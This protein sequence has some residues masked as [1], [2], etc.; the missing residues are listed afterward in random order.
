MLKFLR[1]KSNQ[2]KIYIAIS[3]AVLPAFLIWGVML[4]ND[5]SNSDMNLGHV[6][7]RN[8]SVKDYLASYRAISR[9][10]RWAYGDRASELL[11]LLNLKGEAWDRILL[12]DYARRNGIRA[13]DQ[14]V[15]DWLARQ[16]IFVHD[17]KFDHALYNRYVREYLNTDSRQFEEEMRDSLTLDKIREGFKKEISLHD[18]EVRAAYDEANAS[19]DLTYAVLKPD[20]QIQEISPDGRTPDHASN[21]AVEKLKA[22]RPSLTPDTFDQQ[23]AAAGAQVTM[24]T[25]SQLND[26]LE[27]VGPAAY[28]KPTVRELNPNEISQP[29]ELPGG[30]AAIVKVT[31]QHLPADADY[32][33]DKESFRANLTE[34]KADEKMRALLDAERAKLK[35]NMDLMK[36]IFEEQSGTQPTG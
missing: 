27:H 1:H 7:S 35:L 23:L 22:L 11:P 36:Q 5:E 13:N 12:L 2:K 17:G 14:E 33:R 28:L 21:A 3:I 32:L 19:Y 18:S 24:I 8:I 26:T 20:A 34:R 9:Q 30:T 29:I 31:A 4:E 15:I 16:T 25:Q 6:D 10:L